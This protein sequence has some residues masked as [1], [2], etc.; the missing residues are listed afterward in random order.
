MV[1]EQIVSKCQKL[2]EGFQHKKN[3]ERANF[4]ERKRRKFT[5]EVRK[6]SASRAQ[7][8]AR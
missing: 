7:A 6:L 8:E 1:A 2:V 4:Y 3:T 5:S